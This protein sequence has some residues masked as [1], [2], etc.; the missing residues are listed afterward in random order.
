[1]ISDVVF[2]AIQSNNLDHVTV[3]LWAAAGAAFAQSASLT[4]RDN[5]L[6]EELLSVKRFWLKIITL[7]NCIK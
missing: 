6:F 5:I 1:M 3:K 4:A 2:W 7:R